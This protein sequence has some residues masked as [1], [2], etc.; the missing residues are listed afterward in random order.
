L[1]LAEEAMHVALAAGAGNVAWSNSFD[2][3]LLVDA[4]GE[5]MLRLLAN[6]GRNA[7][8][9]LEERPAGAVTVTAFREGNATVIDMSDNGT[10]IPEPAL[11][12][13]FE[14]FARKGRAGGTGLGLAIARELA[15]GHGGDVILL[16][17]G[18]EG[19]TFRITIPDANGTIALT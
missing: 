6:I 16:R 14:P 8:Q 3:H 18:P 1:P 2:P 17:T 19:T 9:A 7:V 4:D 5:Q 13:L 10:G 15:R 12:Q 11:K